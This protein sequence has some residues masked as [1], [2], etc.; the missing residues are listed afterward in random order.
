MHDCYCRWSFLFYLKLSLSDKGSKGTETS[1]R[2]PPVA[3][4]IVPRFCARSTSLEGTSLR[5]FNWSPGEPR[6]RRGSAAQVCVCVRMSVSPS[7]P[8]NQPAG[9]ER[10]P[11][12][13][14]G[15]LFLPSL[16]YRRATRCP[17]ACFFII[18]LGRGGGEEEK[19]KRH[20]SLL[21][22]PPAQPAP[23]DCIRFQRSLPK[24]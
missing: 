5:L 12:A 23:P 2:V 16:F 10:S 13:T 8:V 3:W 22:K 24:F 14:R 18:I 4:T 9:G 11:S 20:G 17:P 1:M 7:P 21:G 15:G 6:E 19:E